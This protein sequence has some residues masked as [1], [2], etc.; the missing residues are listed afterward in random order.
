MSFSNPKLKNPA[1]IFIEL[2]NK[3]GE[4]QYYDKDIK[5]YVSVPLPIYFVVL[6]ELHIV[7][8]YNKANKNGVYSNEIRNIKEELLS[9]RVFKTNIKI[10]GLWNKIKGEVEKING[11]YSRS[12][13][14]GL[15]SKDKPLIL[16]NFQFYGASRSPWFDFRGDKETKGVGITELIEDNNG[17]VSFLR[18]VF[19]S[20]NLRD[21]D[22][23]QAIELDREL[24]NYLKHYLHKS[25]E[26]IIESDVED[27]ENEQ[28]DDALPEGD[29][30]PNRNFKEDTEIIDDLPF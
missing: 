30:K 3:V 9:V 2:K 8:G 10:V 20:V 13:Y 16:V 11:Q 4:F 1:K 6:D 29:I 24:Q 15:I 12:V 26:E 14:A 18:P 25:D 7:K 22:K 27:N 19:K 5:K 23:K 17:D 28:S 21:V